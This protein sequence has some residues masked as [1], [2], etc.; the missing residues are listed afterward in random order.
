LSFAALR[1]SAHDFTYG[2]FSEFKDLLRSYPPS[3]LAKYQEDYAL[4]SSML[5][6]IAVE[7]LIEQEKV[8]CW[9][10]SG[11]KGGR[12]HNSP[13]S[14]LTP[15]AGYHDGCYYYLRKEGRCRNIIARNGNEE[16]LS[17]PKTE[18][19]T[20]TF[21]TLFSLQ[22]VRFITKGFTI[23]RR[24]LGISFASIT[25]FPFLTSGFKHFTRV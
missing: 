5:G 1:F 19:T 15:L 17:R 11:P 6:K 13:L 22:C 2:I 20:I 7:R 10:R 18:R 25:P 14:S 24:P 12:R 21:G 16:I 4:K 3:R 9:W 8:N 23:Y